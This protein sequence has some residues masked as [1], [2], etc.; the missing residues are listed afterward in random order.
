MARF[1]LTRRSPLPAEACWQRL[2]DWPRHGDRVPFTRVRV[3]GAGGGRVGDTVLAR[4]RFGPL[5]L[6]DPME[7][8][9]LTAP[10]A[11]HDGVCRLVKRGRVVRGW[12]VLTV[13]EPGPGRGTEVIWAE[14]ISVA[15][16]PRAADPLLALSGRAV[17][18]RVLAHLLA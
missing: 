11:G 15:H 2:T 18:G 13:R 12:A 10:A 7:L 3:V 4:T 6:D 8:V 5:V 16:L 1:V 17:F 14:E 9:E